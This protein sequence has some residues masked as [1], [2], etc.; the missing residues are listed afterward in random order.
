V[1]DEAVV[2]PHAA[3]RA[4]DVALVFLAQVADRLGDVALDVDDDGLDLLGP[5]RMVEESGL[6]GAVAREVMMNFS[7]A[8]VSRPTTTK[9]SS[10]SA[11]GSL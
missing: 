10:S 8:L 7:L 9:V 2:G 6:A 4:E 5:R 3:G 11:P 1:L